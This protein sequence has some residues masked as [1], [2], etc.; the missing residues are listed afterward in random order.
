MDINEKNKFEKVVELF[1]NDGDEK[2]LALLY[3]ITKD[4]LVKIALEWR[5]EYELSIECGQTDAE[6]MYCDIINY[7]YDKYN[8]NG[9]NKNTNDYEEKLC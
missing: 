4:Q 7:L 6:Y 9:L 5:K 1:S 2:A 3:K 8:L